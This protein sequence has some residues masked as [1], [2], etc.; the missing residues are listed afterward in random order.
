MEET[1]SNDDPFYGDAKKYWEGIPATVDGMLGGFSHISSTDIAGSTK[2]LRDF[3]SVYT[4]ISIL[5]S[6]LR[7]M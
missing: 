2:F 1:E 5:S 7:L 6:R 3:I 4:L